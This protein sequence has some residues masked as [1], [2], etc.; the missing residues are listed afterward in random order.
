MKYDAVVIGTGQS[1]VPLAKTLAGEGWRTAIIERHLVGGSCI[2]YGCTPSKTMAAS[3]KVI[4]IINNAE[5]YGINISDYTINL[6]DVI[7]RK[8]NIVK[9][10]GGI[11][12][13]IMEFQYGEIG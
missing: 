2:N 4:H 11:L 7:E 10:F 3:S 1:G 8:R 6:E 9:S 12:S 13:S 5:T